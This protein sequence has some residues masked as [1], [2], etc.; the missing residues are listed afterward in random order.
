MSLVVFPHL[1]LHLVLSLAYLPLADSRCCGASCPACGVE[2]GNH[3]WPEPSHLDEL[4]A[5]PVLLSRT[6]TTRILCSAVLSP[7]T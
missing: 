1:L 5:P 3:D 7:L 2:E 4:Q 6:T